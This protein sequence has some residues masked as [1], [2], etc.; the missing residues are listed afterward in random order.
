MAQDNLP[1]L[2]EDLTAF[3]QNKLGS[4]DLSPTLTID[5]VVGLDDLTDQLVQW[6]QDLEP[7]G[8]ANPTPVFLTPSVPVS[9]VHYMGQSRQHLRL[10]VGDGNGNENGSG[11]WTA[12]AFNQAEKWVGDTTRVDL[13]Y[14]ITADSWRGPKA[15]ALR[16]LDFR[17]AQD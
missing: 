4:L 7:Y 8:P 5:A 16:V 2:V 17:T 1:K 6:L 13:V 3:A 9:E 14:S 10:L 12:L 11:R 15:L